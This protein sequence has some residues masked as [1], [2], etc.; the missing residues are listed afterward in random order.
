M[1]VALLTVPPRGLWAPGFLSLLLCQGQSQLLQ[2]ISQ[3]LA[4][5][6]P[7]GHRPGSLD[8]SHS[9]C[10]PATARTPGQAAKHTTPASQQGEAGPILNP[11]GKASALSSMGRVSPLPA[12]AWPC[13]EKRLAPSRTGCSFLRLSSQGP[14]WIRGRQEGEKCAMLSSAFPHNLH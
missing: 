3:A 12:R 11:T 4:M 2:P 8:T 5:C 7:C 6:P 1:K 13:R 10:C 9:C 14:W